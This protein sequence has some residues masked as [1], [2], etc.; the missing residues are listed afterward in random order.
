MRVT[1]ELCR[2]ERGTAADRADCHYLAVLPSLLPTVPCNCVEK[3]AERWQATPIAIH[4]MSSR[5]FRK[6]CYQSDTLFDRTNSL[7][8]AATHIGHDQSIGEE[9]MRYAHALTFAVAVVTCLSVVAAD[10]QEWPSKPV[11]IV[12]PFAAGGGS[13][14]LGRLLADQ[15][16]IHFKQPF[17]VANK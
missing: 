7:L 11:Y 6:M 12:V 8:S 3:S 2:E 9:I 17:I 13:D 16:S 1:H 14:I 15:L 10:A 5:R 4:L